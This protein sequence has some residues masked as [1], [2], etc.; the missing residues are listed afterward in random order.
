MCADKKCN[1]QTQFWAY[2]ANN[3][4]TYSPL[5]TSQITCMIV[6]NQLTL[7]LHTVQHIPLAKSELS[8]TQF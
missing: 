3:S 2:R 5:H 4:F 7:P 8:Y 1:L 6:H